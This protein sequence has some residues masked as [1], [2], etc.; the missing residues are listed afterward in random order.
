MTSPRSFV[1]VGGGLAGAKAVETLRAEGFPDRVLLIGDERHFPYERPPLSKGYLMGTA[2]RESGVVHEPSWFEEHGVEVRT[3][4]SAVALDRTARSVALSDG[5]SCGFDALLL[6][7][8]SRPR[9]LTVP[10][11]DVAGVHYLRTVDDADALRAGLAGARRVA[12]IGGGWIGLEVAAA[13]RGAG[14]EVAI[15]EQAPLPLHGVLGPEVAAAFADLHRGHGV[16]LQCGVKVGRL[17]SGDG[18]VTG[19]GL[20]DG[21]RVDADLVV[22]GIGIVPNTSLAE[23][24]G[25]R[26]DNGIRVDEHLRTSDPAIFAAGD[27]ANAQHPLLGRSVRVEHWAN[28]LHQGPVAARSMLGQDASYTRLPYFYTDQY[29][30]GME[31]VGYVEPAGYDQVV[32]RGDVAGLRFLAFWLAGGRVL[33]GMH[34]NL[35]D[36]I[37]PVE[38]LIRSGRAVDADRLADEAVPLTDV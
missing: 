24:A 30:L 23:T 22:V 4:V 29:D 20:S 38:T 21:T 5:T 35:W 12:V 11:A 9:P 13:A 15:L 8:G 37:G 36:T 7:T 10:G 18:A 28:A 17:L 32:L 1:I 33:A 3:G 26:V 31:Y 25:L 16:D 14:A 2:T 6:A 19:V 34:V 27:V